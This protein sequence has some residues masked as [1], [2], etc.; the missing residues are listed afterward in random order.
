MGPHKIALV[1]YKHVLFLLLILNLRAAQPVEA[2]P[3]IYTEMTNTYEDRHT[4]H[5][6]RSDRH[7]LKIYFLSSS[8]GQQ[9]HLPKGFEDIEMTETKFLDFSL[10]FCSNFIVVTS[11]ITFSLAELVSGL[12]VTMNHPLL[13]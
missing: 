8:T 11:T 7:A 2:T 10:T 13:T 1:L 9:I 4:R 12:V 3:S 6:N 5:I